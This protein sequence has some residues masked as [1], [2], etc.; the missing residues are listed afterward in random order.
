MTPEHSPGSPFYLDCGF[1]NRKT[2]TCISA[3]DQSTTG[4]FP[5][6][7]HCS[8]GVGSIIHAFGTHVGNWMLV[9]LMHDEEGNQPEAVEPLSTE[10]AL[11]EVERLIGGAPSGDL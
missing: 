11:A 8:D 2:D 10:D 7:S 4:M 3:A 6:C 5:I 1:C 9:S